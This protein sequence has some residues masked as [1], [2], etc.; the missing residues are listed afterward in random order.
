MPN[1]L[2]KNCERVSISDGGLD[3][4]I[5][6]VVRR[7][8][9]SSLEGSVCENALLVTV[10]VCVNM[11]VFGFLG[12]LWR[13]SSRNPSMTVRLFLISPSIFNIRVVS[14]FP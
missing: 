2:L 14:S 1:Y 3:K 5:G 4:T 6:G 11:S 7:D 12:I 8:A 10:M 13:T 9:V